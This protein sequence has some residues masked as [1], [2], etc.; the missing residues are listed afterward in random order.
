VLVGALQVRKRLLHARRVAAHKGEHHAGA[1]RGVKRCCLR[2]LCRCERV[3]EGR[4]REEVKSRQWVRRLKLDILVPKVGYLSTCYG[5][6]RKT[7]SCSKRLTHQVADSINFGDGGGR[8]CE[9]SGSEGSK[10]GGGGGS[11][12]VGERRREVWVQ[13]VAH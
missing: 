4:I 8:S 6:R 3:G 9:H 11:G 13:G 2:L 10:G 7:G 1:Q 5:G 12:V